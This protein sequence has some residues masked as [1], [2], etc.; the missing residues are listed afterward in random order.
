MLRLP[1]LWLPSIVGFIV[2]LSDFGN[3]AL[4]RETRLW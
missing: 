4:P 1:C 3:A 2:R